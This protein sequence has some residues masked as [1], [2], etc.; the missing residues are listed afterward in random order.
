MLFSGEGSDEESV[1]NG[2]LGE[3]EDRPQVWRMLHNIGH[4]STSDCRPTN[5]SMQL[6]VF[7]SEV[8]AVQVEQIWKV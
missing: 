8:W 5:G 6:A 1:L 2:L 3:P 7:E 4:L